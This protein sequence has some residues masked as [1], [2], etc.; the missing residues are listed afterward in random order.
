MTD[1]HHIGT[2]LFVQNIAKSESQQVNQV[3]DYTLAL[4]FSEHSH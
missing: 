4:I 1:F 2:I 3:M